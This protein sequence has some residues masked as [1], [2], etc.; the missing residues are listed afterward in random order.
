MGYLAGADINFID[1][2][3]ALAGDTIE[4]RVEI[5]KLWSPFIMAQGSIFIDDKELS[6]ARFTIALA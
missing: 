3:T 2:K 4:A 5:I 1:P 6:R